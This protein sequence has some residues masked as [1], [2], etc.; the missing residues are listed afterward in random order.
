MLDISKSSY[1]EDEQTFISKFLPKEVDR[2]NDPEYII[3]AKCNERLVGIVTFD[4]IK[5]HEII[6]TGLAVHEEFRRQHIG[7]KLLRYLFDEFDFTGI[8]ILPDKSYCNI[9]TFLDSAGFD[10]GNK[11]NNVV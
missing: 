11:C 10:V 1:S 7:L 8:H 3:C 4:K 2:I 5:S 6:I 9:T